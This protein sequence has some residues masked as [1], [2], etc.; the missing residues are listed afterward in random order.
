MSHVR[1]DTYV[2][3]I[4]VIIGV[5]NNET[6]QILPVNRGEVCVSPLPSFGRILYKSDRGTEKSPHYGVKANKT[7]YAMLEDKN[8]ATG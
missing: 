8:F 7:G 1:K 5:L 2:N 6:I 3:I 4:D